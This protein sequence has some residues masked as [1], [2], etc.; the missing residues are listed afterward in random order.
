MGETPY[1]F[2]STVVVC[3]PSKDV[4]R[5]RFPLE[6]F[7]HFSLYSLGVETK[8][9]TM[10]E[11][12]GSPLAMFQNLLA[13]L[14]PSRRTPRAARSAR[15]TR[16]RASS[17]RRVV[18][19]VTSPTRSAKRRSALDVKLH[20]AIAAVVNYLRKGREDMSNAFL[21]WNAYDLIS[22]TLNPQRTRELK[23]TNQKLRNLLLKVRETYQKAGRAGV[24][25][26]WVH[27]YG[28]KQYPM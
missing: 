4:A 21:K 18:S 1:N 2:N 20:A 15:S 14:S 24:N 6:V 19:R 11:M 22:E 7:T 8:S 5:V 28:G 16:S 17:A 12:P 27:V 3:F 23:T 10:L 9:K 13:K 25:V 26:N